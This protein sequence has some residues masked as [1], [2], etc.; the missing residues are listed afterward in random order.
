[1]KN[2]YQIKWS[3][4]TINGKLTKKI[5]QKAAKLNY[6]SFN[7]ALIGFGS[8]LNNAGKLIEILKQE[9]K[10]GTST[11]ITD[12]QFGMI[13]ITYGIA[14]KIDSIL[15]SFIILKTENSNVLIP[16]TKLQ[17]KNSTVF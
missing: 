14:A 12:K 2:S 11:I 1:M 4:F 13:T 16:V 15:E 5:I 10:S 3:I 8:A 6:S 9:G 17:L 7:G